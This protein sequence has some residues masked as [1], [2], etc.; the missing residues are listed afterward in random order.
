[1]LLR[2]SEARLALRDYRNLL[3]F[4]GCSTRELRKID[5]LGTRVSVPAN[6][7]IVTQGH[8]N[9]EVVIVF[10]G[11]ASCF[12]GT[13]EVA[14]FA[15]GDFFG[16]VASLDHGPRTATVIARTAMDLWVLSSSEF[17][18]FVKASPEIAHRILRTMARRLRR[19]DVAA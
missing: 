13:T 12:V 11:E 2:K 6:R 15:P 3:L 16:E 8:H 19:A 7:R 10:A 14:V 4:S 9:A 5:E 18:T 1:L 17:E